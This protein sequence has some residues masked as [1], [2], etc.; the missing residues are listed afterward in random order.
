M[1]NKDENFEALIKRAAEMCAKEEIAEFEALDAEGVTLSDETKQRILE[2]IC[3]KKKRKFGGARITK[4]AMAACVAAICVVT[5]MSIRPIRASV[6]DAFV[7]WYEKYLTISISSDDTTELPKKIEERILPDLPDGWRIETFDEDEI[8]GIYEIFGTNGEYMSYKQFIVTDSDSMFDNTDCTI[9][10][11][12]F[13]D[14]TQGYLL[15]YSDGDIIL[16]WVK[17]YKFS[18]LGRGVSKDFLIRIAEDI[19]GRQ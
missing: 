8:G 7:T 14:N 11:V 10:K 4:R 3:T 17:S 15:M 1:T 13:N 12:V 9:E 16:H 18:L 19:L 6:V 2:S 5:A